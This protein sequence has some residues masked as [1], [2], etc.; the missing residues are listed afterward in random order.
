MDARAEMVAL[1]LDELELPKER[2]RDFNGRRALQKAMYLLQEGRRRW[3]F[4]F[5]YN[6]YIRGP[7]SPELARVGYGLL[8]SEPPPTGIALVEGCKKD[9][10]QL[11]ECFGKA[12]GKLDADLLELAATMHFLYRY[13]FAHQERAQRLDKAKRWLERKKPKLLGRLG[14]AVAKLQSLG[15]LD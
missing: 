14:D 13:S 10:A 15:M 4:G 7:Y 2:L 9:I 3:D 8:E 5:P 1:V 11:R 12:R 6:L